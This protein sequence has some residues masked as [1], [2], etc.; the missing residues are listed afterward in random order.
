MSDDGIVR[1]M[2]LGQGLISKRVRYRQAYK[3]MLH[4]EGGELDKENEHTA[5][6]HDKNGQY[7]QESDS[8]YHCLQ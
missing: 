7:L 1:F 8:R 3:C 6:V 4:F 5:L 2:C